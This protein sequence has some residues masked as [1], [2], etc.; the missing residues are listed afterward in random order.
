MQA[1]IRAIQGGMSGRCAQDA[2]GIPR[3]TIQS[4]MKAAAAPKKEKMQTLLDATQ[5]R[6]NHNSFDASAAQPVASRRL[7]W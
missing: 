7:E 5:V 2:Y 4:R 3:A 1:A 6:G